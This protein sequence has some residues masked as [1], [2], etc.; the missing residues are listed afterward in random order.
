MFVALADNET[1]LATEVNDFGRPNFRRVINTA[2]RYAPKPLTR[3]VDKNFARINRTGAA[4]FNRL[5]ASARAKILLAKRQLKRAGYGDSEAALMSIQNFADDFGRP[6]ISLKRGLQ[7]VG[8]AGAAVGKVALKAAPI[9]LPVAGAALNFVAPGVGGKVA[10]IAAKGLQRIGGAKTLT[11]GRG[12]IKAFKPSGGGM[13]PMA[14]A[15]DFSPAVLPGMP[16]AGIETLTAPMQV[17]NEP[18]FP[19]GTFVTPAVPITAPK[20]SPALLIGAGASALFLLTR[21]K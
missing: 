11:A 19:P 2:K 17:M 16:S 20:V 15:Q 14:P 3:I 5:P 8:R 4:G 12:L 18:Q 13:V 1:E 10:G 9:L 7:N 6:E 21:K